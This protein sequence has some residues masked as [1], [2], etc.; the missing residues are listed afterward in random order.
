MLV[1]CVNVSFCANRYQTVK[2]V[3][4]Y[5][6][7][8]AEKTSQNFL[9]LVDK[10]LRKRDIWE[11]EQKLKDAKPLLKI[12]KLTCTDR[13][14][15]L[16][17]YLSFSPLH[18]QWDILRCWQFCG[19][20]VLITI[21]PEIFKLR[22]SRHGWAGCL[23]AVIRNSSIDQVYAIEEVYHCVSKW[24]WFSSLYISFSIKICHWY[25]M[26]CNPIIKI[27]TRRK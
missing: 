5:V 7:K 3:D 18:Q 17:V 24:K 14:K 25:T 23:R 2:M 16:I 20:F 1:A 19:L 10:R 6:D 9:A 15:R 8:Y 11:N 22:S 12:A 27:F 26:D 21:S 4:I 13:E